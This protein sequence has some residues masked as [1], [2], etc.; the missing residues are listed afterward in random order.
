MVRISVTVRSRAGRSRAG[1]WRTVSWSWFFASMGVS[2]VW[3]GVGS[4][5]KRA[6]PVLPTAQG[7][8]GKE[9]ARV[10]S[11]P[12]GRGEGYGPLVGSVASGGASRSEGEG[13][14]TVRL[15]RKHPLTLAANLRFAA[16]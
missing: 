5:W 9:K 3:G 10:L 1:V 12:R 7:R 6:V 8:P 16:P 2:G 15:L 14:S 11:S 4:G 13:V